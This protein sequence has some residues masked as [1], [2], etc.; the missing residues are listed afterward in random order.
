M[1]K[2]VIKDEHLAFFP[3]PGREKYGFL[4]TPVTGQMPEGQFWIQLY[5]KRGLFSQVSI[6]MHAPVASA[7]DSFQVPT[8]QSFLVLLLD[9]PEAGLDLWAVTESLAPL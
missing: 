6:Q 9:L 1:L 4:S 2:G 7:Q 8:P 3:C 5:C